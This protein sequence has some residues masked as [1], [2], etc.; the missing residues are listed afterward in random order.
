MTAF[1]RFTR[2]FHQYPL[3][4]P[5]ALMMFLCINNFDILRNLKESLLVTR[6]GAEII[7]FVKFW[8][9]VPAALLFLLIYSYLANRLDRRSLFIVTLVPFLIWIPLFAFVIYPNLDLLSLEYLAGLLE[10]LLP[11]NLIFVAG[12]VQYWPLT[13]FFALAELWGTGVLCILFWTMVNDSYSNQSATDAYP[14][15]SLIGNMASL[16]SGPL[17]VYC[18]Q[19]FTGSEGGNWQ[20]SLV[21]ISLLFSL[22][23]L[24]LL[25]I[26]EYCCRHQIK[27][28]ATGRLET[29]VTHLPFLQ[30]IQYLI[31]SPYL[32]YIAL[33]MLS[34]CV[35]IN[36]VE[37][38][39]KSQL[40]EYYPDESG[41]SIVM[42][43][44]TFMLGLGC[45]LC[46]L[47]NKK[48]LVCSWYSAAISVPI[49]MVIT[50]V[51][52]FLFTLLDDYSAMPFNL[53]LV[54]V[55]MGGI[56]NVMSKSAKY[57]L[58]DSSKE[59]AFV[60]LDSEQ[61]Y[62]GKAAIEL[63]VSRLGKSGSAFFQQFLILALGSLSGGI[64]WLAGAFILA[65]VLWFFAVKQLSKHYLHVSTPDLLMK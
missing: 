36:M 50:A 63:V 33:I 43:Y 16:F 64:P 27:T 4:L 51:P 42:G 18:V 58:F 29:T 12:L 26:H 46:G 60:P 45:I 15:L 3:L 21:L 5:H 10:A 62:K 54:A 56:S 6:L 41:Y 24:I 19:R 32:G 13:L 22:C 35:A 23:G 49:I 38:A 14:I 55:L 8:V 2:R 52:F 9:V 53:L 28:A 65:V 1:Q 7:P 17:M 40:V 31:R 44:M 25:G 61:K 34:Y 20:S 37:V 39:W 48:L 47:L 59:L 57:T 11:D 30:S